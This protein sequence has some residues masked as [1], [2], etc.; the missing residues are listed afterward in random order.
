[1]DA[2]EHPSEPEELLETILDQFD[3][4]NKQI[5]AHRL[6]DTLG[7]ERLGAP[8]PVQVRELLDRNLTA[9]ETFKLRILNNTINYEEG[10]AGEEVEEE[11]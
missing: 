11:E 6:V 3:T 7:L 2:T 1:M 9:S 5:V 8:Y 10:G 4:D